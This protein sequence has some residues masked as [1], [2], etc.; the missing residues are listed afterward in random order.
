VNKYP[1]IKSSV[2]NI[3]ASVFSSIAGMLISVLLSRFHSLE[4][5]GEYAYVLNVTN[6]FAVIVGSS[7]GQYLIIL[8]SL[9]RYWSFDLFQKVR[10]ILLLVIFVI[11]V[12]AF[13]YYFILDHISYYIFPGRISYWVK[14]LFPF[15]LLLSI[16]ETLLLSILS[17]LQEF[18]FQLKYGRTKV[19]FILF[20]SPLIYFFGSD[21]ALISFFS[22]LAIQIIFLLLYLVKM[23]IRKSL[24]LEMVSSINTIIPNFL[25]SL[26]GLPLFAIY[27]R[28]LGQEENGIYLL[29][30]Y[31]IGLQLRNIVLF[32]PKK[33][34]EVFT[35]Y[36]NSQSETL[37]IR[38]NLNFINQISVLVGFFLVSFFIVFLPQ[39]FIFLKIKEN[40]QN[41]LIFYLFFIGF[42]LSLMGSGFSSLIQIKRDFWFGFVTNVIYSFT[43]I[44]SL[45]SVFKMSFAF[46]FALIFANLVNLTIT[47]IYYKSYIDYLNLFKNSILVFVLC[48]LCFLLY[49]F[50]FNQLNVKLIT[51]SFFIPY[52][53]L[54]KY[55]IFNGARKIYERYLSKKK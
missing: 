19:I 27:F 46:P 48:F 21:G 2:F 10:R 24:E 25:G 54:Y 34:A 43:F 40:V 49:H 29:G 18:K 38:T 17:G 12:I 32:V 50:K 5:V 23:P 9:N 8:I 20:L 11:L 31:S 41:E 33:I 26:L 1:L 4:S 15:F 22:T 45:I 16:T 3:F 47:F 51:L 44:L 52:F 53:V 7:L 30:I 39:F 36:Q 35:P 42:M 14:Y 55:E 37:S 28:F 13:F 6:T